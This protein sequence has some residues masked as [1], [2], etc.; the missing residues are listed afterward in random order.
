M[1]ADAFRYDGK[2]ALVVGGATG[3]GAAT[4]ELVI[5]RELTKTIRESVTIDW[6]VSDGLKEI[7]IEQR[8]GDEVSWV[9]GRTAAGDV[10]QRQTIGVIGKQEQDVARP[11]DDADARGL[12]DHLVERHERETE[13]KAA[14]DH[15]P[16]AAGQRAVLF[17]LRRRVHCQGCRLTAGPSSRPTR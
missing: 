16:E 5:A 13:G 7:P 10:A 11:P 9:Q 4:A 6:T 14:G 3:M 1:K 15:H 8:S 2:R 12:A 17:V